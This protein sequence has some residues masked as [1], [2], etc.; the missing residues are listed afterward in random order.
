LE[1]QLSFFR[2]DSANSSINRL[3]ADGPVEVEP[4]LFELLSLAMRLYEESDGAY[5]ITATPLWEV[6]GFA[7]RFGRVPAKSQLAEAR[8]SVGGHLVELDAARSTIRF[9]KRGVRIS[10]GS[11]G[12]GYALDRCSQ[13]LFAGGM[14]DF[15]L[16]GDQSS[17]LA[18]G[19]AWE[20]GLRS[21]DPPERRL[22][23]IRLYDR[24]LGTSGVQ[25]QSFRHEGRR[26][27]HLLDPRSG[28]PAEGVLSTTVLAPTAT[29]ADA[30]ST[31]MFVMGAEKASD[32]CRRHA[33]I[34][35]IVVSPG[36]YNGDIQVRA[37][38]LAD[39]VWSL[40]PAAKETVE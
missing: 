37:A 35:L 21:P 5:D 26:L 18:H 29:L 6:W 9:L 12:K 39:D 19:P 32:Y 27:G 36:P 13:R 23:A 20:V 4:W 25:F 28:W 2:P 8:R 15:L 7:Q 10:L 38:G 33:D 24:A 22:G 40:A 14:G 3:A 34:G 31:A 11:I 16:H 1:G 17:V 30:L